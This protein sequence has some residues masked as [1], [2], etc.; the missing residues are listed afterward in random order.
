MAN[1]NGW[2]DVFDVTKPPHNAE[3]TG[4]T[5]ARV[6]HE[7][8]CRTRHWGRPPKIAASWLCRFVAAHGNRSAGLYE[9]GQLKLIS[10]SVRLSKEIRHELNNQTQIGGKQHVKV[11]GER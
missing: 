11:R 4:A 1:P 9:C 6:L 5:D 8:I 3:Q 2:I 10:Q 7:D